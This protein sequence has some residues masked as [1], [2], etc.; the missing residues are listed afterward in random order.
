[1]KITRFLLL[2][3]TFIVFVN[4]M[5]SGHFA[6]ASDLEKEFQNT[7][8][9]MMKDPSNI[10]ITMKYA[11]LAVQL[12]DYESAI[13]PLER[14]LMF[15]PNLPTIKYQLGVLYY[16]LDSVDMAKSYFQDALATDGISPDLSN[17][18]KSYLSRI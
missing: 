4:L 15:N 18:I 17:K 3:A 16:K 5:V 1:M 9:E 8:D 13:P 2:I 12:K 11:N 10:D 6:Y 14:I 7:F